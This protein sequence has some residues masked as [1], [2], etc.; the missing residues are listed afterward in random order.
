[1]VLSTAVVLVSNT[2]GEYGLEDRTPFRVY[3]VQEGS[4]QIPVG[5]GHGY[6]FDPP[7]DSEVDHQVPEVGRLEPV[8]PVEPVEPAVEE[9]KKEQEVE[10]GGGKKI[11]EQISNQ[12]S[13]IKERLDQ[14][15]EENKLLKE[16]QDELEKK[17]QE[18]V[19]EA[20]KE[21]AGGTEQQGLPVKE[22]P[23][24]DDEH[25]KVDKVPPA[26]DA[27][28]TDG[29]LLDVE[30]VPDEVIKSSQKDQEEI[31]APKKDDGGGVVAEKIPGAEGNIRPDG[32]EG[33]KDTELLI[34]AG[35][36]ANVEKQKVEEVGGEFAP[37][38]NQL[39]DVQSNLGGQPEEG[40][41]V[42]GVAEPS[43]DR[44][45]GRDLKNAVPDVEAS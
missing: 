1:M 29:T 8:E 19:E 40:V 35:E 31:E 27:A 15:V 20:P 42:K 24:E 45:V 21:E 23:V 43:D 26:E 44:H 7:V 2:D 16:K 28:P 22:A 18:A 4:K 10:G 33:V 11:H 30:E 3:K 36:K 9:V 17:Q 34:D 12:I 39:S 32:E 37:K 14:V 25:Q 41:A 13:E 6:H 38:A 5:G